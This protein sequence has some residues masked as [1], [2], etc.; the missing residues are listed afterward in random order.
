MGLLKA[1][2]IFLGG[3]ALFFVALTGRVLVNQTEQVDEE[4]RCRAEIQDTLTQ[5]QAQINGVG[6]TAMLA[7][8]NSDQQTVDQQ[9][10]IMGELIDGLPSALDRSNRR[11]EIC[12]Q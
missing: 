8:F 7:V 1:A 9:A 3:V 10:A 2:G 5:L 6:W 4:T 11:F 12:N